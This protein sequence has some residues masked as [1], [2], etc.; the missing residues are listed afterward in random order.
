MRTSVIMITEDEFLKH[1]SVVNFMLSMRAERALDLEK[2]LL[3]K[4]PNTAR[5][6]R[7]R[8]NRVYW[9][10]KDI[11]SLQVF[12]SGAIQLMGPTPE[13]T[14]SEIH[15]YIQDLLGISV[16]APM[17]S[18]CTV[19]V[20]LPHRLNML[21]SLNS[22]AYICNERELFPGTL[23]RQPHKSVTPNVSGRNYHLSLFRNGNIVIT[24]VVS[25]QEAFQV[26]KTCFIQ[27]LQMK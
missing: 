27:N 13:D 22:N 1:A 14:W 25:L 6:S 8:P 23:I 11:H 10:Y 24:G 3:P 4:L 19:H 7:A 16:S 2:E 21:R 17:V 5:Y 15:R 18:S 12:P 26:Y 9:R 20:R